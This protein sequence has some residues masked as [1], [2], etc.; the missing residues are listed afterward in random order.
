MAS[1]GNFCVWD[2][3]NKSDDM[4]LKFGNTMVD[5]DSAEWNAAFGT[6]GMK[7]GKWYW[8][9]YEVGRTYNG[10][11]G[12]IYRTED[13]KMHLIWDN[14]DSRLGGNVSTYGTSYAGY[15]RL[16]SSYASKFY[17]GTETA[18]SLSPGSDGDIWQFAF[19][20]DAG[21]LWIG[22]D[23][24]WS[25][26]GDPAN[27]N[28]PAYSSIPAGTYVAAVLI[29]GNT[30]DTFHNN[31]GQDDTF[32]G[33]ISAAGNQD[34][35]GHGVF[36]YAPPTG[37]LAL[38]SANL[39]ISD[40]IDPG[41]DNGADENPTKQFNAVTYTGDSGS[42]VTVSTDFQP[43][44]IWI[45]NR[46]ATDNHYL[47]DSSRGFGNSK[48]LSPNATG[49]TGYNGGAPSSSGAQSVGSSSFQAYGNDWSRST[50]DF[51]AWCWK[52]NGGT[53]A[54]NSNG[55]T[56][57]TVQANQ[58][59]GVSIV[60][61][62]GTLTSSGTRT[63]GHGLSKAPEFYMIKQVNKNTGRWF[64][65]HTGMSG[66]NYMLELNTNA[67]ESDKSGNGNM[68][69]PTNT[70]FST[71]YTEAS[72][73][74]SYNNIAY[75]WHSVEGYS[76]FESYIGNGNTSGPVIYTGFRPKLIFLKKI[77]SSGQWNVFYSP[78]KTFNSSANAYLTWNTSDTEANGVPIDFLSNGFKI[79]SSGSGVNG[80]GNTFIYGAWGD[81]PFK[82]ANT[83]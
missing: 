31:W 11:F 35:N 1:S 41:G 46:D 56:T 18:L 34:E 33:R 67:A 55:Q 38:C 27:G 32:G 3:N 75:V 58:E 10:Y 62:A 47:Q 45:K 4:Q 39:S 7:T 71:N 68:S 59:A 66:A 74:N 42:A 8:E 30:S 36:K 23:N 17:N 19:D 80:D 51:I 26:S 9:V 79:R 83:F 13:A 77:S 44:L 5:S 63:I 14:A 43:D 24:T 64:V 50:D 22:K 52:V 20:A 78:P 65:W 54:S 2:A 25:D 16:N 60:E 21:K 82:Y 69:L 37:F 72:N 76:K 6:M 12:G 57:S 15:T 40:D 61:Y 28:N 53:T 81:V 48:S 70:V 73:E 49:G 29:Y